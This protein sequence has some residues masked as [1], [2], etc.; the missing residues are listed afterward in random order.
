MIRKMSL[1]LTFALTL[2][3]P[4]TLSG[5]AQAG[6]CGYNQCWGAVGIGPGTLFGFS[7]GQ[8][9][10]N[11]ALNY[12]W[13]ECPQ[14]DRYYTFYN[15]CGAIA[16]APDGSWGSGWGDTRAL[17]EQYARQTCSKYGSGCQTAVWACSQ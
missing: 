10:E 1:A 16:K 5:P 15:A 13:N 7:Y 12:M 2:A 9:S 8:I 3:L 17:A 11:D 4:L 6:S 14:C